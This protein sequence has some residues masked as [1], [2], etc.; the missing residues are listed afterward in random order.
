M[1]NSTAVVRV[2]ALN[3]RKG[4]TITPDKNNKFPVILNPLAGSIPS[5]RT[6][7]GT[8]AERSDLQ[9]GGVYMIECTE[10]EPVDVKGEMKRQFQWTNLGEVKGRDYLEAKQFLGAPSV[11]DVNSGEAGE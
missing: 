3:A 6:L 2:E 7:A 9:V 5:F 8:F 10:R 11:F 1:F 4:E